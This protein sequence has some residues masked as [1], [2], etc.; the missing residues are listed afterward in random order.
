ME[1][2]SLLLKEHLFEVC[3]VDILN[4]ASNL[5]GSEEADEPIRRR[6]RSNSEAA[7]KR[8]STLERP[9]LEENNIEELEDEEVG[10][11][12]V[13]AKWK[14]AKKGNY[15]QVAKKENASHGKTDWVKE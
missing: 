9:E 11:P 2:R 5:E 13:P 3:A 8:S 6:K 14:D 7:S 1:K 10:I 4:Q 15:L 12:G